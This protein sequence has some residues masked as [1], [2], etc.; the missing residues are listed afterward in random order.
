MR[1]Q[2]AHSAVVPVKMRNARRIYACDG[3][4]NATPTPCTRDRSAQASKTRRTCH[5]RRA[6][7]EGA[8]D[9]R[10]RDRLHVPAATRPLWQLVPARGWI[11]DFLTPTVTGSE[12]GAAEL[13]A[14]RATPVR[15]V[16]A[17]FARLDPSQL[18]GW[19]RSL[20]DGDAGAMVAVTDA[21]SAWHRLAVAPYAARIQT[22]LDAD[23]ARKASAAAQHGIGAVLRSLHPAVTWCPP[24]L[25]L[26]SSIDADI[27]LDGRGLCL[28]PM[29]FCGPLPRLRL[30]HDA[31]GTPVLAYQIASDPIAANPL[32]ENGADRTP[33]GAAAL[34]KLLG[35]TRSTVLHAIAAAPGLTTA[36]LAYRADVAMATASEHAT[37]LREAG[38]IISH[39]D[40]NRVRHHPTA[41]ASALLDAAG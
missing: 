36:Q 33:H 29:L 39:R 17:D 24:V 4:T 28:A 22:A 40:G 10:R 5:R 13:E 3:R 35:G 15:Q 8:I 37:V 19:A 25:T 20:A 2:P 21:L 23:R 6:G 7:I 26:P 38:L 14:I 16:R 27:E 18:P 32:I 9:V 1:T 41:I 12:G 34:G 30:A 31:A 11:P